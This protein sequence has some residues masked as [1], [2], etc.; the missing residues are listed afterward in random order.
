MGMP[1]IRGP[2]SY[3]WG[4]DESFCDTV[5]RS[6]VPAEIQIRRGIR[7]RLWQMPFWPV[8]YLRKAR[9]CKIS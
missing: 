8:S 2:V 3:N 1:T 4:D 9:G 5:D 6:G 7:F